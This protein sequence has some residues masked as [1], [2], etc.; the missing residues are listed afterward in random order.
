MFSPKQRDFDVYV[1]WDNVI[2]MFTPVCRMW[3]KQKTLREILFFRE[4]TWQLLDVVHCFTLFV[5]LVIWLPWIKIMWALEP[6]K[7]FKCSSETYVKHAKKVYKS[8]MKKRTANAQMP[9]TF[10]KSRAASPQFY[11]TLISAK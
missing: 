5:F 7:T 11:T 6:G 3:H 10:L 9:W 2:L 4:K 1:A 8:K